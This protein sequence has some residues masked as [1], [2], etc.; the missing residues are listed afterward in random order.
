MPAVTPGT[1]SNSIPRPRS[2]SASSPPRPKTNGS[3]PLS[4]TTLRPAR[5]PLG[6]QRLDLL[7]LERVASRLLADVDELGVVAGAVERAGRDQAVVEDHVGGRDQLER[8]RRHQP[9][10]AGAGAD[11]I[12]DA[13]PGAA[14]EPVRVAHERTSA[15]QARERSRISPAPAASIRSASAAPSAPG[16]S[17]S[18]A[19]RSRTQAV[20]SGSPA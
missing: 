9:G 7:L 17:G 8:A 5:R 4:R 20:P 2:V 15:S 16:W 19:T 12:G 13:G 11:E 10:I 14:A 18:P 6:D 1:T 3:P